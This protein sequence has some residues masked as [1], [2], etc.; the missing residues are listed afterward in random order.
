[1]LREWDLLQHA[2]PS[3]PHT[4]P[5]ANALPQ[6]DRGFGGKCAFDDAVHRVDLH[7]N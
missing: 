5:D 7:C 6:M 1:M 3:A 4:Q 2:P